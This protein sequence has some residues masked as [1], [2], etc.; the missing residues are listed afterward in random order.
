[1]P[2]FSFI[3]TVITRVV[4]GVIAILTVF[5]IGSIADTPSYKITEENIDTELTPIITNDVDFPEFFATSTREQ[6]DTQE[7][8]PKETGEIREIT[9]V[10]EK[11]IPP[12]K[13]LLKETVLDMAPLLLQTGIENAISFSEIN[14][15]TA[16]ALVNILCSANSA[17][18]AQ[19]I[20]GSG[21]IID[22]HGVVMTNAHIAQIFLVRD[23]PTK[24]ALVC[25]IRVGSPARATYTAEILY[26][27]PEWVREHAED[28][29]NKDPVGTG[30]NDYAFLRITGRTDPNASIPEVFPFIPVEIDDMKVIVGKSVLVSAYPAG[31][32]EGISVERELY[33]VSSVAKISERFTF[34]QS[35]IDLFSIGGTIVSQGGSSGGAVVSDEQKL[36][37]LVVTSTREETTGERDLRAITLGHINR[38]LLENAQIDIDSLLSGDIEKQADL[39]N[40]TTAPI[41]TDLLTAILKRR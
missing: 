26:I 36:L 1:M 25:I 27:S 19:P 30:E 33:R 2:F 13:E 37:G 15:E 16:K 4:I 21:V 20:T 17:G 32:L 8:S 22:P 5:G 28:I 41:L 34:K 23:H 3:Q 38:S 24:D 29:I 39:F 6:Q 12:A 10:T 11:E 31:F 9:T 35:T 7:A 14:T 18:T 40:S